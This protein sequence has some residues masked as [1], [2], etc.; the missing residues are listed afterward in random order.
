M[1]RYTNISQLISEQ[2]EDANFKIEGRPE[3]NLLNGLVQKRFAYSYTYPKKSA[4]IITPNSILQYIM[5]STEGD[6]SRIKSVINGLSS[7]Q[8]V[9]I[10]ADP[11]DKAGLFGGKNRVEGHVYLFKNIT[12]S[13]VTSV[14]PDQL[15][16]KTGTNNVTAFQILSTPRTGGETIQQNLSKIMGAAGKTSSTTNTKPG[17]TSTG[18]NLTMMELQVIMPQLGP[19]GKENGAKYYFTRVV[20]GTFKNNDSKT[21]LIRDPYKSV[22]KTLDFNKGDNSIFIPASGTGKIEA[23][24]AVKG[25]GISPNTTVTK[26]A[27]PASGQVEIFISNPTYSNQAAPTIGFYDNYIFP[28]SESPVMIVLSKFFSLQSPL[29]SIVGGQVNSYTPEIK[30]AFTEILNKSG[31]PSYKLGP[32]YNLDELTKTQLVSIMTAWLLYAVNN[33]VIPRSEIETDTYPT[34]QKYVDALTSNAATVASGT[35][36]TPSTMSQATNLS[37]KQQRLNR[38][39]GKPTINTEE[40]LI[41]ILLG[42]GYLEGNILDSPGKLKSLF[43]TA[44]VTAAGDSY[45]NSSAWKQSD[46]GGNVKLAFETDEIGTFNSDGTPKIFTPDYKGI[47]SAIGFLR[48]IL[49]PGIPAFRKV[50]AFP[51]EPVINPVPGSAKLLAAGTRKD[52]TGK[53]LLGPTAAEVTEVEAGFKWGQDLSDVITFFRKK[54]Y[55][56]P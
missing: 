31:D 39:A 51:G 56:I 34:I 55:N 6:A 21:A 19:G 52:A 29:N 43:R 37:V 24:F 5:S 35:A 30:A 25:P 16:G 17:T 49:T 15:I 47:H 11:S 41:E 27:D 10:S 28:E 23:G 33:G 13:A 46:S 4:D 45:T 48:L 53:K 1:K 18:D 36:S 54:Y 9:G 20:N 38:L 7:P 22:I 14:N 3:D 26:K 40:E 42:A 2:A 8:A 12:D 32:S 50:A 44:L